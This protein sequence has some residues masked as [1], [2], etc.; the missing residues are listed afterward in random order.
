MALAVAGN[1]KSMTYANQPPLGG[2]EGGRKTTGSCGVGGGGAAE[3]SNGN[4][5]IIVIGKQNSEPTACELHSHNQLPLSADRWT[6]AGEPPAQ[7]P[8]SILYYFTDTSRSRVFCLKRL[9]ERE[10]SKKF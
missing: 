8:W 4:T 5:C 6:G 10:M 9:E 2:M 7:Q 1:Q 3:G